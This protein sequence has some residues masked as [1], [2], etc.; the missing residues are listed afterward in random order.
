MTDT[1]TCDH[2]YLERDLADAESR[3]IALEQQLD[4]AQARIA[5]LE[6]KA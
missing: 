4:E 2:S 3:T 1:S 5:D 6:S